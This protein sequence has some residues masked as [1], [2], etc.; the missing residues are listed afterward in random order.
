M[1]HEFLVAL[2]I[3]IPV[4]LV[5]ILLFHPTRKIMVRLRKCVG[6]PG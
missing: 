3:A 6:R 5:P 1:F 4:V 2:S